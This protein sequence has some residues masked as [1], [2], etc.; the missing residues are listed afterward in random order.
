MTNTQI[1]LKLRIFITGYELFRIVNLMADFTLITDSYIFLWE[2]NDIKV[3]IKK[4]SDKNKTYLG[5]DWL[6]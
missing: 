5:I 2:E 1:P 4:I 6:W 3:D